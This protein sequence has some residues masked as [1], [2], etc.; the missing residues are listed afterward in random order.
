MMNF[1]NVRKSIE[2][3][4]ITFLFKRRESFFSV[5][6]NTIFPVMTV[7]GRDISLFKYSGLFCPSSY[8]FFTS[9]DKCGN[10]M[11]AE[12]FIPQI[13]KSLFRISFR[14][15]PSAFSGTKFTPP[16]SNITFENRK[17]LFTRVAHCIKS[18]VFRP[19]NRCAFMGTTDLSYIIGRE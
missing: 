15:I 18:G 17:G 5:D 10:F 2:P 9:S 12:S 13:F 19:K 3:T 4:G 16:F 14:S 6:S 7:I 1:N 8:G 11:N